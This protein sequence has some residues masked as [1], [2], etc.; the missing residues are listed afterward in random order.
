MK[1]DSF[2]KESF[3]NQR[4]VF[5]AAF[6]CLLLANLATL[7]DPPYWDA[8]FYS[9]QAVWLKNNGF[10]Y[11]ELWR[12]PGYFG[13]GP[14]TNILYIMAPVNAL[15]L[16]HLTPEKTF[17]ILHIFN[18]SCAAITFTLFFSILRSCMPAGHAFVW[19]AAAVVDPI[20]SGQT[21]SIYIEMPQAAAY[22]AVIYALHK[23]RF[24]QA[25]LW[26]LLAY[27]IKDSAMIMGIALF[28]W[29]FLQTF[30][31]RLLSA[32]KLDFR[33]NRQAWPI[34]FVL[35]VFLILSCLPSTKHEMFWD[36]CRV[37]AMTL[38]LFPNHAAMVILSLFLIVYLLVKKRFITISNRDERVFHTALLLLIVVSG[39]WAGFFLYYLPL[40]RYTTSIIFPMVTLFGFLVFQNSRRL[41]LLAGI[42]LVIFGCLNQYGALLPSTSIVRCRSGETLE[43]SREFL[44][45]LEA[46]R[47]I[48]RELEEK[49]FHKK[50]VVKYPFAH[51]LTIPEMG[52]VTTPLPNVYS[53]GMRPMVSSAKAFSLELLTD[54]ET[55]YLYSPNVYEYYTRPWLRPDNED[56]ILFQ[57]TS[58]RVPML[59]FKRKILSQARNP[60]LSG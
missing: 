42:L 31:Y 25:C 39:F 4:R 12:L 58:L 41:S 20:F 60:K 27:L 43:R 34:L 14:N 37:F 10:N 44:I 51:M 30:L 6:F 9:S 1:N 15:L 7:I 45:D 56:L 23:N 49:Y 46:N 53:M 40:C 11:A 57:D 24:F 2:L 36:T 19:C 26:C 35:P 50:I 5:L 54:P 48:C 3:W 47:R 17:L 55:L 38:S 52:Y 32:E 16:K 59:L 28:V 21:A 13:G 33:R 18:I 8:I 29:F 22:G